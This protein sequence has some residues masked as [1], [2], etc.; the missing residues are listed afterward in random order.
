MTDITTIAAQLDDNTILNP[1]TGCHEWIGG[2]NDQGYGYAKVDGR[3]FR[4]HRLAWAL[5][6]GPIPDGLLI[7]HD[8]D[9]PRCVNVA[10]LCLGTHQDNMRDL[11][12]RGRARHA[13]LSR[14]DIAAIKERHASGVAQKTIAQEFGINTSTVSRIINQKRTSYLDD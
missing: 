12:L 2:A 10:H 4:V 6:N 8:C 9:N 3:M 5:A 13:R 11:A 1:A 7:R 14:A